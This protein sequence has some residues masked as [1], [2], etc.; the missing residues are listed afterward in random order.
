MQAQLGYNGTSRQGV[1]RMIR[2]AG[3]DD[4]AFLAAHDRH[5]A[6]QELAHVVQAGRVYIAW[7]A[8]APVGWLRW[9]LFWDNTPFMNLLF[10][11]PQ[12]RGQGVAAALV[13]RWEADMH[14]QGYGVVM[15]S[16]ASDEDAQG[17]YR[18]LGY[19]VVGGFLPEGEPYELMFAKR[20]DAQA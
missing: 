19:R 10:V 1:I 8:D 15:T 20:L 4:L 9:G 18:H 2:L 3:E 11:L 6:A 13:A 17:L 14:A 5:I 16:T 7:E 12:A